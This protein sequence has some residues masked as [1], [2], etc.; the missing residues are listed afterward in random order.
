MTTV[1]DTHPARGVGEGC[2]ASGS[3]PSTQFISAACLSSIQKASRST[4]NK[5]FLK[6]NPNQSSVT[7][8]RPS[9][10]FQ[11][12]IEPDDP[13]ALA[14]GPWQAPY[15]LWAPGG[16]AGCDPPPGAHLFTLASLDLVVRDIWPMAWLPVA[17]RS[18][19]DAVRQ[20]NICGENFQG[21]AGDSAGLWET[22]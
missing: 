16:T 21:R 2:G 8:L 17:L 7:T 18:L 1:T 6:M 19:V 13:P 5:L 10:G 11:V 20:Q 15:P 12:S 9:Q 14:V 3:C 22:G 4:G